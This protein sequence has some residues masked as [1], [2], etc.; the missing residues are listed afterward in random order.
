MIQSQ[1][2]FWALDKTFVGLPTSEPSANATAA[3]IR[4]LSP[5][6]S[7]V[8]KLCQASG[9]KRATV[10]AWDALAPEIRRAN[11]RPS[12]TTWVLS[13]W[14]RKCV[15]VDI[16]VA[17][18]FD[19]FEIKA[20]IASPLAG[21][22]A[23]IGRQRANLGQRFLLEGGSRFNLCSSKHTACWCQ[24]LSLGLHP[25]IGAQTVTDFDLLP[26]RQGWNVCFG[27][28]HR[29][30]GHQ[31]GRAIAMHTHALI[32]NDYDNVLIINRR[33]YKVNPTG[34]GVLGLTCSLAWAKLL[35]AMM[36][37]IAFTLAMSNL[38]LPGP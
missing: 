30:L 34:E 23:L 27:S 8:A 19:I 24:Q 4:Q 6:T 37:L 14:W 16:A 18:H 20:W 31:W 29:L 1:A 12:K 17:G 11:S 2:R 7:K 15:C 21:K 3:F 5:R 25:S 26:V 35:Q 13:Y 10:A 32:Q 33:P 36:Q 9:S 22:F 38:Y 28:R